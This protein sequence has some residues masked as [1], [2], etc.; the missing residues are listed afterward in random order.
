MLFYVTLVSKLVSLKLEIYVIRLYLNKNIKE[1]YENTKELY[2]NTKEFYENTKELY[3]KTALS[4]L[5]LLAL[6]PSTTL[7]YFYLLPIYS[8]LQ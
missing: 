3:E 4:P 5:I 7:Y 8:E 1:L 6:I 2:E